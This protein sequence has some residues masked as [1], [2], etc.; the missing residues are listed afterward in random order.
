MNI[1]RFSFLNIDD[2][3]IHIE[4][5]IKVVEHFLSDDHCY[6]LCTTSSIRIRSMKEQ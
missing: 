5:Y 3:K 4:A 2:T 6:R 1:P